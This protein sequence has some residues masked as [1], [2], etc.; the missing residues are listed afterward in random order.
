MKALHG[1]TAIWALLMLAT[2]AGFGTARAGDWGFALVMLAATFKAH[3]IV[4]HY[5]ELRFA[6][7]AWRL[8]FDGLVGVSGALILG[9]HF[10]A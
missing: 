3:L 8:V 1:P 4:R 5:M 10:L 9:L 7:L 6:P 2:L